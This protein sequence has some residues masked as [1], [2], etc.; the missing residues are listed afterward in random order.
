LWPELLNGVLLHA[1]GGQSLR[2]IKQAAPPRTALDKH[3]RDELSE[4]SYSTATWL[5]P[6]ISRRR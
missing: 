3:H 2:Q 1:L 6:E 5:M 4:I